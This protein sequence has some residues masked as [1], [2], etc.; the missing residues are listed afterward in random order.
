VQ[1]FA[2]GLPES[3]VSWQEF[4]KFLPDF[5]DF[6]QENAESLQDFGVRVS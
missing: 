2:P 4:Y 3:R 1:E 6:R 5:D